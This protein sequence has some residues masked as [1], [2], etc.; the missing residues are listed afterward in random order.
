MRSLSIG[1]TELKAGSHRWI[2]RILFS[3]IP[4]SITTVPSGGSARSGAEMKRGCVARDIVLLEGVGAGGK[5]GGDRPGPA[6][7]VETGVATEPPPVAGGA[8]PAEGRGGVV[9]DGLV[10]EMDGA[11]VERRGD[12]L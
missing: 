7:G 8:L 4:K 9:H 10:T 6:E 2:S 11:H 3:R 12:L 1:T 5:G